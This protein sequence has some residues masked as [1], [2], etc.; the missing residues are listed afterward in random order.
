M[1]ALIVLIQNLGKLEI[2]HKCLKKMLL[3][4]SKMFG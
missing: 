1:D 4:S 3:Y 2:S